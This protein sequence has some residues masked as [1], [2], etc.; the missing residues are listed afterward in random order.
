MKKAL[1]LCGA[2]LALSASVAAASVSTSPGPTAALRRPEQDV[3]LHEQRTLTG[4]VMVGSFIPPA[5][6]RPSR[7]EIVIDP[8]SRL[9][10]AAGVVAVQEH[11]RP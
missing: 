1:L 10:D 6:T 8:R 3:R 2:L 11:G 4:A 9:G 5:G 7:A